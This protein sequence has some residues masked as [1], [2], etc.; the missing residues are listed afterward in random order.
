[1][2]EIFTGRIGVFRHTL[3]PASETFI[4]EQVR[5]L[6]RYQVMM[7]GR[8]WQNKNLFS[9][10]D[11]VVVNPEKT[12]VGRLRELSY[13]LTS[14]SK[15]LEEAVAHHRLD[16]IHAHFGVDGLYALNLSL[17]NHIPL[18]TTFHGFDVTRTRSALIT[19][20][21]ASWIRYALWMDRLKTR[22][23]LFIAVS[24]FIRKQLLENGFPSERIVVHHI[25]VDTKKFSPGS[26]DDDGKM[27]LTVGRLVEKKGTEYLI[28]AFALVKKSFPETRL[29]IIGDGPLLSKLKKLAHY[30]GVGNEVV[31]NKSVPHVEV[32]T[33]IRRAAVFCLP[34]VTAKD[35]DS[36]GLGMV[37]AEAAACGKP[38][39]GTLHGGIPEVVSD[40]NSGFL[41]PERDVELLAAKLT[42]LMKNR[43][44]RKRLGQAGRKIIVREFDLVEQT[45][46]LED[47]YDQV[48]VKAKANNSGV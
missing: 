20:G 48:I 25:G 11:G 34:S 46:K 33:A 41:V 45:S 21:K 35:G 16:L 7:L 4:A 40:N 30:L 1:M 19:S 44:L 3:L 28:R 2:T 31:F 26:L 9:L 18:V 10:P 27:I 36:E 23:A 6:C 32:L 43:D 13:M 47:L 12:M 17:A 14:R 39:V 5:H 15:F 22:G 24:E 29:V 37:F 42:L 38:L 8:C